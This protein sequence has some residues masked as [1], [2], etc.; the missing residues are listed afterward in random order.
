M[1]YNVGFIGIGNM[2]GALARSIAINDK[3]RE[4]SL[5]AFD[6]NTQLLKS[7]A[8]ELGIREEESAASLVNHSDIIVLAVKPQY[9]S[10]VLENIKPALKPEKIL[11][12]VAVGLSVEYYKNLLGPD[13][14][15][16]R[17]MPNT[18]ALVGAG[19]T[20]V[21]WDDLITND[22]KKVI[23]KL[24]GYSGLVEE[25]DESLMCEVTALTG[26][27]PA[28]VFIMIEAMA[29][30]AV[31]SGIPRNRA[32]RLAAQAVL[33]SAKMVLDTGKHPGELKDMVCSPAGTTI[34]AVAALEREGFR[35]AIMTAMEECTRRAR[36][37]GRKK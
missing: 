21:S 30:A 32:Y 5:S 13:A 14:K 2:G 19:M 16:V 34:E 20:L 29:D 33:G 3:D 9:C 7:I 37:I 28:Y 35:N 11:V 17:T 12:S 15:V 25:L 26:S 10:Q 8:K 4:F 1:A 22:E 27:S 31:K 23:M 24:L 36:E 18:P 6:I